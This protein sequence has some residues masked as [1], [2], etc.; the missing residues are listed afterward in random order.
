[1]SEIEIKKAS[2]IVIG[3]NMLWYLAGVMDGEGTIQIVTQRPGS[4]AIVVQISNTDLSLLKR[5]QEL[6]GGKIVL[7]GKREGCKQN[8]MIRWYGNNARKL[9]W[10]L[11]YKM[12]I[13]NKHLEAALMLPVRQ[14]VHSMSEE[15]KFL[16]E[17]LYEYV[18]KLNKKGEMRDGLF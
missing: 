6:F 17:T 4:Y 12:I 2:E 14:G 11:R 5:I 13:K 10:D 8:Y 18:R 1:M 15:D 9:L 16:R 3:D 7:G